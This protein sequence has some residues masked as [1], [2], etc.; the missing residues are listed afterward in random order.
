[1]TPKAESERIEGKNP[2][3]V[4]CFGLGYAN[5]A[6]IEASTV[7]GRNVMCEAVVEKRITLAFSEISR[8]WPSVGNLDPVASSRVLVPMDSES[9]WVGFD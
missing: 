4:W 8:A 5:V 7:R 1:M 6:W 9:G 2:R 3:R